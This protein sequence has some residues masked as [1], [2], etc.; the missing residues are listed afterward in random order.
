MSKKKAPFRDVS[1]T[2]CTGVRLFHYTGAQY[3][4]LLHCGN[5]TIN[6]N[7]LQAYFYTKKLLHP[8]F[9]W[10]SPFFSAFYELKFDNFM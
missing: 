6:T 10:I 9:F 5:S 8:I 3:A 1:R 4:L 7:F 2:A